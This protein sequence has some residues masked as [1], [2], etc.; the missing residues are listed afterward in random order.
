MTN[1][2]IDLKTIVNI[3]VTVTFLLTLLLFYDR[4]VKRIDEYYNANINQLNA[5]VEASLS[6]YSQFSRYIYETSINNEYVLNLV[7]TAYNADEITQNNLRDELYDYLLDDYIDA[8]EHNFRQLHFHFPDSTSFLRMHAPEIYGDSLYDVRY[9]I[10]YVNENNEY[11]S[12]FEEGRIFN[13]YRFVFPLEYQD[14]HIGSVEVS[15]SFSSVINALT[16]LYLYNDY[17]FLISKDVVDNIVFENEMDNYELSNLS[18]EFY[19]DVNACISVGERNIIPNSDLQTFYSK[20]SSKNLDQLDQMNPFGV[21]EVIDGVHYELLFTPVKNIEGV[22]VGYF[23][24]FSNES[25]IPAIN[26]QYILNVILIFI[27]YMFIMVIVYLSF[28]S[29]GI[30][31]EQSYTDSLTKISN[32]RKLEIDIK[33]EIERIKRYEGQISFIMFDIDNFKN[34]NDTYGHNVGD[35]ALVELTNLVHANIRS[36]DYFARYGGEEF[37]IMFINTNLVQAK[38]KAEVLRKI[39]LDHEF[40]TIKNMSISIGVYEYKENDNYGDI[41]YKI[42][43]ALYD[44]KSSGKNKVSVYKNNEKSD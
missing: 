14:E 19:L 15:V 27:I 39:V 12:G 8:S 30:L 3:I 41:I 16:D 21:Y 9:S 22:N 40:E 2:V 13:G 34:I 23:I 1:R 36:V 44:A 33:S 31:K 32:R 20:L 24:S 35:K 6:S 28:R 17:C 4:Y 18:D 10:R 38:N 5:Q 29:R 43:K 37:I 42:D 7:A 11:I 25:G 26:M